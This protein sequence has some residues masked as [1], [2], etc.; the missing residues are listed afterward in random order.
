MK[1]YFV[2]F[3]SSLALL[4]CSDPTGNKTAGLN[5]DTIAVNAGFPFGPELLTKLKYPSTYEGDLENYGQLK[6]DNMQELDSLLP[7]LNAIN[8]SQVIASPKVDRIEWI[9]VGFIMENCYTLDTLRQRSADSCRYRLPNVEGYECY[10]SFTRDYT[11]KGFGSYG[12]LLLLDPET[13]AGKLLNI[14]FEGAN[15]GENSSRY[16]Y[17]EGNTIR[18]FESFCADDGIFIDERFHINITKNGITVSVVHPYA[19]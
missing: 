10:Y 9:P 5:A 6:G 13:K 3:C 11:N 17:M 12:N 19:D 2:L 15:E 1:N 7:Q 16:F 18:L 14:Y 8:I 4:S